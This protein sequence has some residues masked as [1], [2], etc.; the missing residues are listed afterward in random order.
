MQQSAIP[1]SLSG[2]RI[3]IP[4]IP[5]WKSPRCKAIVPHAAL[6]GSRYAT[7]FDGLKFAPIKESEIS[8]A[9]TS[10]YF[11]DMHKNAEVD[12]VIVGAGS[13][14]LSCAYELS[15]HPEISV[16][17]IEQGVAPGGGAW[18]GGQLFSAM[19]VRKPAHLF[20]D[21]LEISYDDE[22]NFVV[23][24]HAALFT[25]T[26]LSK[27]LAAPNI[28]L[29]NATAAEDL[30]VKTDDATNE[31]YVSGAVTN[32]TLVSLNHDTTSCMDPNTILSK[33]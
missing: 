17:I 21:E 11:D 7:P 4:R 22:G 23:V 30:I 33:V 18:L 32:W 1:S 6:E 20:L 19:C 3:Q 16:A 26:L 29:F 15:K 8:R 9:M 27:V 12:V 14:G 31:R 10:R 5:S 24:K 28:K 25:S 2:S 13:A